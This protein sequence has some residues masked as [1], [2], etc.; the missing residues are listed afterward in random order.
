[1]IGRRLRYGYR[2]H[3]QR[4]LYLVL[5]R[6]SVKSAIKCSVEKKLG[7]V[8]LK[9]QLS[10]S[11]ISDKLSSGDKWRER[12]RVINLFRINDQAW[13]KEEKSPKQYHRGLWITLKSG[14]IY[15]TFIF[16]TLWKYYFFRGFELK[17]RGIFVFHKQ[18]YEI[19]NT[20]TQTCG[21][22]RILNKIN[23]ISRDIR[24]FSNLIIMF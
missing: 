18:L 14:D 7:G 8:Y 24:G 6:A 11:G 16:S 19:V 21:S 9:L 17:Y 4:Y 23:K 20:T 3:W 13:K 12:E 2:S 15:F 5:W 22:L 10:F 1:M